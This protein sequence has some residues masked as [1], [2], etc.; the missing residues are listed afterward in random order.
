MLTRR[1]S[2]LPRR[3]NRLNARKSPSAS[4]EA[5]KRTPTSDSETAP[6]PAPKRQK[7][8]V[9]KPASPTRSVSASTKAIVVK[10]APKSSKSPRHT[11][12]LRKTRSTG[13]QTEEEIE[14]IEASDHEEKTNGVIRE[15]FIEDVTCALCC[16]PIAL[17][18]N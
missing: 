14:N 13:V 11:A 18:S 2:Q 12:P 4:K 16:T 9:S 3:S 5:I 1:S 15:S 6:G 17:I 8:R 10:P 7:A